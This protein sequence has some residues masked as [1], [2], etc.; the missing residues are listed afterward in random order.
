[1]KEAKAHDEWVPHLPQCAYWGT[2]PEG[3]GK[4]APG[5]TEGGESMSW[6]GEPGPQGEP[7][8]GIME[9]EVVYPRGV[10]LARVI[11]VIETKSARGSGAKE[12]PSRIVTEYWSLDG[13]KLAE[14]DPCI[15]KGGG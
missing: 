6:P 1:M 13:E 8:A 3:E 10:D 12:Q 2:F 4:N 15:P 5:G 11:Q 14:R 7:N 9:R